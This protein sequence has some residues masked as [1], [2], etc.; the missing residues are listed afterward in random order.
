MSV[1]SDTVSTSRAYDAGLRAHMQ[2]VY[3]YLG[4]G[5]GV[6]AIS[7]YAI[8][9]LSTT[10]THL[11]GAKAFGAG[12]WLTPLGET[13]Y[14]WPGLIGLLV[15][16]IGL[17]FAMRA[18]IGNAGHGTAMTLY[19]VFTAVFGLALAAMV[20]RHAPA[21]V[22][23][24]LS[25]T[26]FVFGAMSLWGYTTKRDLSGWGS[27]LTMGLLGLIGVGLLNA[28]VFHSSAMQMA[29]SAAGVLVFVGFVA[30]DT[31]KI[32]E[33]YDARLGQGTLGALAVWGAMELYLDVLNLLGDFLNLFS[34]TEAWGAIGE[35]IGSVAESIGDSISD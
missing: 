4:Y 29:G 14:G 32:K 15:V 8:H 31:Q 16:G 18:T 6:S 12:Q 26:A 33:G 30:Y 35:G 34:S 27:F 2:R 10:R 20:G 19:I 9:G 5:L 3:R 23:R 22:M 11:D 28:L 13:L 24:A 1:I 7:A 21:V 17:M 25:V